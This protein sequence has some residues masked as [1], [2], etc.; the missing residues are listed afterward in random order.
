MD[1]ARIRLEST[2]NADA[3]IESDTKIPLDGIC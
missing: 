1:G 2:T 3:W